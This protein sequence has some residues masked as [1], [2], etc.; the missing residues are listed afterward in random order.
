MNVFISELSTKDCKVVLCDR[1][2]VN[3]Q[4]ARLSEM[5]VRLV[6]ELGRKDREMVMIRNFYEGK[7]A[8]LEAT[9][10]IIILNHIWCIYYS[11]IRPQH[12]T[13]ID[14]CYIIRGIYIIEFSA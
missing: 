14:T 9:V 12:Q 1:H 10:R 8:S 3:H 4:I 5:D 7:L 11:I 2:W 6:D 13:S